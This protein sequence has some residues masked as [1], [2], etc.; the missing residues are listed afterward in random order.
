M[1]W[2]ERKM[3]ATQMAGGILAQSPSIN[4]SGPNSPSHPVCA[5]PMH[6]RRLLVVLVRLV[7]NDVEELELVH[8]PRGGDDA[9]PVTELLLLEELLGAAILVLVFRRS[10]NWNCVG[11]KGVQVLEVAAGQVVVGNDLDLAL[12]LL[13][14]HDIV[15]QVV[16]AALDLDAV[17]E[18][19]LEGGDIEDLVAGGLRSVDDELQETI[20]TRP[21]ILLFVNPLLGILCVPSWSAS[22]PCPTSSVK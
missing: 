7:V 2:K 3:I 6:N 22:G 17:L 1:I 16:G 11:G 20:S 21:L 15:A 5:S 12:A 14:D 10:W 19:L 4:F 13:L 8:T 18:E 9:E